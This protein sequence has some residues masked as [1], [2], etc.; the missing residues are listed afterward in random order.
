MM[1]GRTITCA[2]LLLAGAL[3]GP[4]YGGRMRSSNYSVDYALT[5]SGGG[6][7]TSASYSKISA[8]ITDGLSGE[9]AAS[10]HYSISTVVGADGQASPSGISDWSLY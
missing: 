2:A 4:A 5:A 9:M 7:S 3:I 6:S 1:T 8:V 10:S